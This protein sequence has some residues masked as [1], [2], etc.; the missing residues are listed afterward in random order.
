MVEDL[1]SLV[2]QMAS[3]DF[4]LDKIRMIEGWPDTASQQVVVNLIKSLEYSNLRYLNTLLKRVRLDL[5]NSCKDYG[6]DLAS[7]VVEF[8]SKSAVVDA[9][10]T[11]FVSFPVSVD[12]QRAT[13]RVL[14]AHNQLGL[15]LWEAGLFLAEVLLEN[16]I[17][18]TGKTVLELESGSGSTGIIICREKVPFKTLSL[19]DYSPEVLDNLR[20]N[21]GLNAKDCDMSRVEVKKLDWLRAEKDLWALPLPDIVLAAD[22]SYAPDVCDALVGMLVTLRLR[23]LSATTAYLACTVRNIDTFSHLLSALSGSGLVH[24]DVTLLLQSRQQRFHYCN[25][26]IMRLLKVFILD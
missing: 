11:A 1:L 20:F 14:T 16:P 2:L 8:I 26:N 19:T 9:D 3:V 5:D 4:V 10:N 17:I 23:A 15:R 12:D 24:E 6:D 22:C 21:I 13:C 18:L 7:L 25:R